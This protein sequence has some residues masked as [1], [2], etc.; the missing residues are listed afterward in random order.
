[1]NEVIPETNEHSDA[2][3]NEYSRM[4][5]LGLYKGKTGLAIYLF[6]L[7][8]HHG[9]KEYEELASHLIDDIVSHIS[10]VLNFNYGNGL[11][12]IGSGISYLIQ[13]QFIEGDEDEIFFELDQYIFN[14]LYMLEH[15]D[16][17]LSTGVIGI[18]HYYLNR[19]NS[20]TSSS[21]NINT[22]EAKMRL[23]HILDILLAQFGINGYTYTETKKLSGR[24]LVD[25]E[26]FLLC[27]ISNKLCNELS[28]K[29][30]REI[31]Q[32]LDRKKLNHLDRIKRVY[33]GKNDYLLNC[34]LKNLLKN[35]KSDAIL[36][37]LA[38][39]SLINP[40]LPFWWT[41]F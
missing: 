6:H 33:S 34:G 4:S 11:S 22:I 21:E 40:S 39:L 3:I 35:G 29:I 23:L 10:S 24:E 32:L 2:F 30:L 36:Q 19:I 9:N 14:C 8:R 26:Y 20:L 38:R 25:I 28:Y 17:C 18:G 12:G 37:E 13:N 41:I 1:M 15:T 27:I 5:D 7:S 31:R 16:F